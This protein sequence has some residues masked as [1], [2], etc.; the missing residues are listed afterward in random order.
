MVTAGETITFDVQG[1]TG[2]WVPRTVAGVRQDAINALSPFFDVESVSVD[3]P[4]FLS[5][6]I[7]YVTNWP[8]RATVRATMRSDYGDVRDVDSI[9]AH[10]FYEAAGD[11]P[12]VTADHYEQGQGAASTT[13]GTSVLGVLGITGA[14]IVVALVAIIIIKAE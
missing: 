11:L 1:T 14:L 12:T 7:H 6:P 13:S 5:D 9:V 8:Y 4:S 10:A 2:Q 3:S